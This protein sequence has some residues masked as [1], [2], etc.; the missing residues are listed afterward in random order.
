MPWHVQAEAQ[1]Y[2]SNAPV[3]YVPCYIIYWYVKYQPSFGAR[4]LRTVLG[5]RHR[6]FSAAEAA[7]DLIMLGVRIIVAIINF[8]FWADNRERRSYVR[9]RVAPKSLFP[10]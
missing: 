3:C 9:K 5:I 1:G 10:L 8:V 7:V 4:I 2:G 6:L